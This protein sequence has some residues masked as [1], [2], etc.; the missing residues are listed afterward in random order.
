MCF[1]ICAALAVT[2]ASE[3]ET[4]E[5]GAAVEADACAPSAMANAIPPEVCA[6][7]AVV[8]ASGTVTEEIKVAVGSDDCA[9]PFAM[10]SATG[11]EDATLTSTCSELLC[12]GRHQE[13][14][15]TSCQLLPSVSTPGRGS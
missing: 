15:H 11:A 14:G 9:P 2:K 5:S 3:T 13:S 12:I 8:K 6:T 4:E 7:L 10:A 1:E